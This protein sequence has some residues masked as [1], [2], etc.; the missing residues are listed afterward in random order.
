MAALRVQEGVAAQALDFTILTAARTDET[1]GARREEINKEA[2]IW[3]VPE[4]RI[5]GGKEHRV[6][7]SPA[8][9]AIA[10]RMLASHDGEFV[11]PGGKAKKP[12]S[13][14]AMPVLLERMGRDDITVHGFRATF[15]TWASEISTFPK[16]VAKM[17]L[18]HVIGDK[19]D[20]AYNRGDLFEKRRKMMEAWAN[21]CAKPAASGKVV[22]IGSGK[23]R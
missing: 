10:K 1:I 9:S 6:P 17:A 12:L 7:L 2:T 5:K 8:A 14:M 15:R 19:V 20:A 16:E 18:A 22:P 21:Y 13:N 3:T 23:V 11:F 4:G